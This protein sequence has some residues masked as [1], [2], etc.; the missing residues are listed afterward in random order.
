MADSI[1]I[2]LDIYRWPLIDR[3]DFEKV[4]GMTVERAVATL[5]AAADDD[6]AALD[7]PARI[8]A[9][10]VWIA[11]RRGDASLTFEQAAGMFD[12]QAFFDAIKADEEEEVPLAVNRAQRRST[13]NSSAP[14]ATRSTTRPRKS[15]S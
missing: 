7:I 2:D 3:M 13:A 14:S 11:A 4:A 9:A 15:A 6:E 12:G 5:A 1:T 10:F 8:Q